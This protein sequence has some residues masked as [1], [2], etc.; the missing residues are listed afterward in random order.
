MLN[1]LEQEWHILAE[2][3]EDK[4]YLILEKP[5]IQIQ[6]ISGEYKVEDSHYYPEIGKRFPN[7]S[8]SVFKRAELPIKLHYVLTIL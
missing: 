5:V 7:R 8:I 4:V 3:K 6:I 2:V 1:D